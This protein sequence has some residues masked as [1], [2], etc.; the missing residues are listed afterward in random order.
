MRQITTL[1]LFAVFSAPA[2]ADQLRF[3]VAS[4]KKSKNEGMKG[5]MELLPGGGLR[6]DGVTLKGLIALA[7]DIREEQIAGGPKWLDQDTY[8]L[9]AKAERAEAAAAPSGPGSASWNRLRERIQTLLAERCQLSIRH[10]PKP[11]PGYALVQAK[12]GT[13]LKPTETP[14]QPGTMRDRGKI[15]GRSGTMQMLATVLGNYV[16]RPV[17]DRTGLTEGY[18]YKLEYAQ[19]GPEVTEGASIFTA[20]QEQL[21]LKLEK[22]TVAVEK[23]VIEKVEKPSDN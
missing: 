6:M 13:K 2:P 3:E 21:G 10:D 11:T 8:S 12:G 16:G 19:D 17:E 9:L 14:M 20:L 18:D 4:I 5:G 15:T 1:L 7:Y 22:T 23:I